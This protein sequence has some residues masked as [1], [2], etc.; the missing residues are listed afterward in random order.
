MLKFYSLSSLNIYL[1]IALSLTSCKKEELNID[2]EVEPLKTNLQFS[3]LVGYSLSIANA[4]FNDTDLP[5]NVL[6][7]SVYTTEFAKAGVIYVEINDDFPLPFNG[8]LSGIM[9]I[10]GIWEGDYGLLS[11]SFAE[12]DLLET[13]FDFSG[14]YT[15]P[16]H[17]LSD[18]EIICFYEASDEDVELDINDIFNLTQADFDS[19]ILKLDNEFPIDYEVA[20]TK[21]Y[22]FVS[23]NTSATFDDLYDDVYTINGGGQI[24]ESSNTETGLRYLALINAKL[25]YSDCTLNPTG[26]NG[27]MQNLSLGSSLELGTLELSFIGSCSG[28]ANVSYASGKY[29][30][31]DSNTISLMLD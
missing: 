15:I 13:K 20:L 21:N 25:N 2:E 6:F 28:E 26:G 9:T 31:Y 10:A 30:E 7:D 18:N 22:W 1:A 24:K 29:K 4:V 5:A 3:S 8:N 19:E 12:I 23:S 11:I 27:Y 16:L 17:K 14:I